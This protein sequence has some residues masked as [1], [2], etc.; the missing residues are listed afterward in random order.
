MG[1]G[2]FVLEAAKENP[3]CQTPSRLQRRLYSTY[4]ILVVEGLSVDGNSPL[5]LDK[6]TKSNQE[7]PS[8]NIKITPLKKKRQV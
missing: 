2:K 1:G 6:L 8:L 5:S 7:K 4:V 3:P